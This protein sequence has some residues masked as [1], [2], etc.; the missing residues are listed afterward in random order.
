M[1]KKSLDLTNSKAKWEPIVPNH[2]YSDELLAGREELFTRIGDVND[3]FAN[4]VL[5]TKDLFNF[6][7]DSAVAALRKSTHD[8]TLAPVA[9][10]TALRHTRSVEPALDMIV[11]FL[12]SPAEKDYHLPDTD[13]SGLVFK[14]VHDK[15]RGQ[16]SYMRVYKGELKQGTS[17]HNLNR[18][19]IESGIKLFTPFSDDFQ[20]I[21]KVTEGNITV[22]SGLNST[23]TGDTL[24]SAKG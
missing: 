14:I 18:E 12:P 13:F 21:A 11:D 8:R 20:L 15:K 6:P 19:I 2:R 17:V 23:I 1:S 22:V 9:I 16:L 24:I 5:E 3:V 7:I 4:S 10:G